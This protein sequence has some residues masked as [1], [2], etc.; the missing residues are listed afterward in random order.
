[1]G[2]AEAL[3]D[4]RQ[5]GLRCAFGIAHHIAV[6][7]P[8]HAPTVSFEIC[9]ARGIVILLVD[10]LAAVEFDRQLGFAARQ[11]DD[12]ISDHQLSRERRPVS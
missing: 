7:E 2:V 10:M 1:V 5:H 8:D 9:C 12:V 3:G 6:P 4:V 11:I